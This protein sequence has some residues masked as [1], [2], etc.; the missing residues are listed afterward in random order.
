[1]LIKDEHRQVLRLPNL[2]SAHIKIMELWTIRAE[3]AKARDD[4]KAELLAR[5]KAKEYREYWM[6]LR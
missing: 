4:E 3:L 5:G 1:M 2:I 6:R